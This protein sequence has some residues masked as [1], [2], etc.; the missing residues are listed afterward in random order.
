MDITA[1]IL[2]DHHRQRQAFAR[3]DDVDRSD[4]ASLALVWEQL[5]EFLEVHAAAEEEVFYPAL[6]AEADPDRE[7]TK[8]AIGDHNDIRD[9]LADAARVGVGTDTWWAAVGKARAAN[10]HHMGEEEDEPLADF[11]RHASLELRDQLGVLFEA[12]KH[13]KVAVTLDQSD[14]DPDTYVEENS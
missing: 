3:L 10:T 12:A 4:T 5:A 11:R 8:D 14:K 7:Q 1:L 6:L 2:D 9:A 13:P